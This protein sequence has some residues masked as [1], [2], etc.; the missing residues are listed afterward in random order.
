MKLEE[1]RLALV[2]ICRSHLSEDEAALLMS[3]ERPAVRLQHTGSATSSH[4]GGTA[5]MSSTT[6]WPANARGEALSL[7]CVLDLAELEA[8]ETDLALPPTGLLNVF[9]DY[10]EQPWTSVHLIAVAGG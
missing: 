7:L 8:F 1:L 9:Y 10:E 4:L 6:A 5:Q 2:D 3:L